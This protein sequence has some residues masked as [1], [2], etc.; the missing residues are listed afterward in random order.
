[1]RTAPSRGRNVERGLVTTFR[2]IGP[3][4]AGR[5][6]M[7]ALGAVG[8]FESMGALGRGDPVAAAA[9]GVDLLVI[10]TPDDQVARV[11]ALVVPGRDHCGHP[12]LRIAG[13]GRAGDP[14]PPGLAPPAGSPAHRGHR[15]RPPAVGD[16]LRRGRRPDDRH[17]GRCARRAGGDRRRRRPRRVPR[18]RLHRRQPHGG[19]DRAGGAGG[20]LGRAAPRRLRRPDAGRHRRRPGPRAAPRPH[21]PGRPWG[22]GHGGAA[23]GRAV[24]RWPGTAPSSPPTTPWSAWPGGCRSKPSPAGADA[25]RRPTGRRRSE[26]RWH[27][28]RS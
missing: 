1:M 16:H 27:E 25:P 11:A 2:V 3:G 12:P 15:S 5:S 8:G 6:L 23:P 7:A 21:R 24:D 17:R 19:A 9:A 20:R 28:H 4:R 26:D 22:L 14:P 10:A 18:R 13:P